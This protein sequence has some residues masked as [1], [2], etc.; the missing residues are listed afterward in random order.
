VRDLRTQCKVAPKDRV[1]VTIALPVDDV[2]TFE[3]HAHIV[4]HMAGIGS[5]SIDP[6]AKRPPN[7]AS[8]NIHGLRIYVHDVSDDEAERKR[9][10]K[11]LENLEKQIKGKQSK[12]GNEKFVANAP[13]EVIA[14]ER[15][16]LSELLT[17][18]QSL[19]KHMAELTQ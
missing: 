2:S 1:T 16:R 5:L 3:S 6:K 15:E 9:T 18:Q 8:V 19:Q 4:K 7:A 12:L 17:Q 10:T 14:T 13:P 11:T